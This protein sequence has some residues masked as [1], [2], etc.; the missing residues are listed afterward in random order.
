M[1]TTGSVG[2]ARDGSGNAAASTNRRVRRREDIWQRP[3]ENKKAATKSS[4]MGDD[5]STQPIV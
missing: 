1:R 3:L 2:W 5:L 4:G